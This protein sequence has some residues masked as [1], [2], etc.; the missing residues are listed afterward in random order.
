MYDR[1]YWHRWQNNLE[2]QPRLSTTGASGFEMVTLPA[3]AEREE[4]FFLGDGRIYQGF[5]WGQERRGE[6]A[7]AL[8]APRC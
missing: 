5:V 1:L 4:T 6:V 8:R 7:A 2:R 3:I